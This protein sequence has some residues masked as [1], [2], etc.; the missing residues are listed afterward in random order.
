MQTWTGEMLPS[1]KGY[2]YKKNIFYCTQQIRKKDG[3]LQDKATTNW[4]ILVI[5]A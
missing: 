5:L 2:D 1:K 4:E 3:V